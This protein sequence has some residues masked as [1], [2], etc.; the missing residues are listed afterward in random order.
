[1]K[2]LEFI[3][4]AIGLVAFSCIISGVHGVEVREYPAGMNKKEFEALER[5]IKREGLR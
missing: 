4:S 2:R 5:K 3:K 1:M